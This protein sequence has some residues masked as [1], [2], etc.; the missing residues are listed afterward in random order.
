MN[1]ARTGR[2]VDAGDP[3]VRLEGADLAA[4]GVAAALDV[5]HAEVLAVEHDHARAGA[6]HR[7]AGAR[8]LAQRLG[9]PLALDPERHRRRLA[10]GDDQAV[11]PVEV[12][13][14]AHLAHVGAEAAQH[15]AVRLE[16]ALERQDADSS[17]R[18]QPRL[19]SSCASSSLR[20]SS[21]VIAM[22]RPSEAR[23]TRAGSAKCVVA[24]TIAAARVAGSSD[25]KMPEPTKL[26]SAPSCIISAASAGVAIPPAQNSTTGSLPSRATWRTRSSGAWCSLAAVASSASS[27]T[28]SALDLAA[29]AAHV[30]HGLDDVA[31]AGL[32]LGADHRRALGDPPQRLAEVGG[33]AHE[34]DLELPLVDVVGLVGRRQHLGLVDVVDLERLEHL[35]LG[36]VADPR[37]GH[38][39][40]RHGL[41]DA[42]DQQRV[43]HAGDAAVAADVG[44]HALE[45]HHRGRAG[46]LGDLRLLGVD[47]VHDH[48]ALEHLGQAGLD[49]ESRL[50]A[51][52]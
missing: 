36:E 28:V 33:A 13:G 8:E 43:G 27:I 6:E 9:E 46:V 48:A 31:G 32:A 21:E 5:E 42:L 29:D 19:A 34:R 47:D 41:L 15:L 44:R 49:A 38:D 18:Y 20:V 2:P 16:V 50:V 11:E 4:E 25:L 10:A 14:H 3:Q 52:T 23:A 39:R 30:A 51:H 45:R 12:G 37:L 7:R 24:S 22:P 26:P 40:D 1:T 17:M 35:R